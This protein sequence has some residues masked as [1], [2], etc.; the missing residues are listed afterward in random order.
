MR[1]LRTDSHF[2]PT[3]KSGRATASKLL[4]Q[5]KNKDGIKYTIY[6][7]DL[8]P[9]ERTNHFGNSRLALQ[10][11]ALKNMTD[12]LRN[13]RY[14]RPEI[15]EAVLPARR[16]PA[17]QSTPG[18]P[19]GPCPANQGPAASIRNPSL[20]PA[21]SLPGIRLIVRPFPRMR[22]R[23]LWYANCSERKKFLIP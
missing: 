9:D 15:G 23:R 20:R 22:P 16:I 5:T 6:K 1:I 4:R 11:S 3:A 18:P 8:F 7:Y 17:T 19:T 10:L 12:A 14:L 21:A 2:R 13:S